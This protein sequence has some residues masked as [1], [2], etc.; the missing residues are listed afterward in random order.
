MGLHQTLFFALFVV[1]F[2]NYAF[3]CNSTLNNTRNSHSLSS[4]ASPSSSLWLEYSNGVSP[5]SIRSE[6]YS[7]ATEGSSASYNSSSDWAY[8]H[9]STSHASFT[10]L[11][12]NSSVA[13]SGSTTGH[14]NFTGFHSTIAPR[15]SHSFHSAVHL[16]GSAA[17]VT[18]TGGMRTFG[19]GHPSRLTV[20]GIGISN[21]TT[22]HKWSNA[23]MTAPPRFVMYGNSSFRT[24]CPH[25]SAYH[26]TDCYAICTKLAD[27]CW[28]EWYTWSQANNAY[29]S[30]MRENVVLST[31][32][33]GPSF[34][35]FRPLRLTL[36]GQSRPRYRNTTQRWA[37]H[38]P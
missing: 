20:F 29:Q 4:V 34:T 38:Q 36:I 9:S 14:A 30:S 26:S 35:P 19:T 24:N 22:S 28:S 37:L 7:S 11:P 15:P 23:S 32:R 21:L 1:H 8:S 25:K 16:N 33:R 6:T 31:F 2:C 27:R 5:S 3:Y 18:G 10:I 13:R 12:F 17:R